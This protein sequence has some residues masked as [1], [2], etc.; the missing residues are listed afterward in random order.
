MRVIISVP[1][2]YDYDNDV[3]AS[4]IAEELDVL[5]SAKGVQTILLVNEKP[6]EIVDLNRPWSRHTPWR[7][8]LRKHMIGD[9]A[10]C[11]IHGFPCDSN[12]N[13]ARDHCDIALL[14]T[15]RFTDIN[16]LRWYAKEL[17]KQGLDTG[18]YPATR[19]N[20]VVMEAINKKAKFAALFEHAEE[21]WGRRMH[22]KKYAKAH[23]KVLLNNLL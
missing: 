19:P 18:V 11:D 2:G 10:V 14:H 4:I 23:A 13:F 6:R 5:L 17:A 8:E 12:S 21:G 15:P 9:F 16:F 1:H 3:G 20:D 22:H 7:R